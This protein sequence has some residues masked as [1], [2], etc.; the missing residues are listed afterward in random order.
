MHSMCAMGSILNSLRQDGANFQTYLIDAML[1][2]ILTMT[3]N[4]PC[5]YSGSATTEKCTIN[6]TQCRIQ[7]WFHNIIG[8]SVQHSQSLIMIFI[9]GRK[10]NKSQTKTEVKADR[11]KQA[12]LL[13][14]VHNT[15]TKNRRRACSTTQLQNKT[16]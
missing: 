15:Y 10:Q 9:T 12:Q 4:S 3:A 6:R 7:K 14:H 2:T 13:V 1:A 16:Q 5:W 8:H 11:K